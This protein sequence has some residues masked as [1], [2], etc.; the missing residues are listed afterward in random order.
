MSHDHLPP[1]R[2]DITSPN[3]S[4]RGG[5]PI[6]AL[7]IHTTAGFWPSDRD[8]LCNPTSKVSTHYIISPPGEIWQLV[9][10]PEAAWG[11]G[12]MN[13]PNVSIPIVAKWFA[14]FQP[15]NLVGLPNLESVSIEVSGKTGQSWTSAQRQALVGLGGAICQRYAIGAREVI[16]HA[17]LDSVNRPFCPGLA[18]DGW[19]MLVSDIMAAAGNPGNDG[20]WMVGAG[21]RAAMTRAGDTPASHEMYTQTDQ[22]E[23]S[24]TFGQTGA[25]LYWAGTDR[26][27]RAPK[28]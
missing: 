19:R 15:P 22:G 23:Y 20:D 26:V 4:T 18:E 21:V 3:H 1:I 14:A 13:K 9:A 12:L 11:N 6:R 16:R 7:C 27:Y 24:V 8:W 2:S 25:Y 17:D 10:E 28:V 5:H